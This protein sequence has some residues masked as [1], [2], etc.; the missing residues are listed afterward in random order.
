MS[1][2]IP[3]AF[4]AFFFQKSFTRVIN[5]AKEGNVTHIW[6]EG[7]FREGLAEED[8]CVDMHR[9]GDKFSEFSEFSE[10]GKQLYGKI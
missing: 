5:A 2:S 8:D 3:K 10:L 6:E 4:Y 7:E 9:Y 1:G